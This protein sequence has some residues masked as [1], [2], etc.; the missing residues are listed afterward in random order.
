MKSSGYGDVSVSKGSLDGPGIFEGR[1]LFRSS[2]R[3]DCKVFRISR[4]ECSNANANTNVPFVEGSG[5]N[6]LGC[7]GLKQLPYITAQYMRSDFLMMR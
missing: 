1:K 7:F 4:L 2:R 3:F 6:V 5:S